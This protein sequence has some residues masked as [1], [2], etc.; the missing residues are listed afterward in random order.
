MLRCATVGQLRSEFV[1]GT[2]GR[3]D[4]MPFPSTKIARQARIV[5]LLQTRRIRSQA[6]LAQYLTDDGMKAVSYTHLIHILRGI[7]APCNP[8]LCVC[9]GGDFVI[10]GFDTDTYFGNQ[11]V[12]G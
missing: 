10:Y 4:I 7:Y 11:S 5:E 9:W 6:E 2:V 3:R 8:D 12:G 1:I